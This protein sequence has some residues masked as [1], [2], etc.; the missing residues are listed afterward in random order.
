MLLPLETQH[1]NDKECLNLISESTKIITFPVDTVQKLS[2]VILHIGEFLDKPYLDVG[3]DGLS[4][5]IQKYYMKVFQK[6]DSLV[7]GMFTDEVRPSSAKGGEPQKNPDP[8]KELEPQRM[9]LI[10][11]LRSK[12]AKLEQDGLLLA[13]NFQKEA[14]E[15]AVDNVISLGFS[16]E[17][18]M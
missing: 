11:L 12:K 1:G 17:K 5:S 9:N 7:P 8:E 4:M 10:S 14:Y 3:V 18:E 16:V 6:L 2:E 15:K 13:Q